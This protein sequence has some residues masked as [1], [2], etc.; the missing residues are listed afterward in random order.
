MEP[1]QK[2]YINLDSKLRL[3]IYLQNEKASLA[4]IR[5]TKFI[6]YPTVSENVSFPPHAWTNEFFNY[7]NP[8]SLS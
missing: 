6:L 7:I 4:Y 5:L 2:N 1:C 3:S 8:L